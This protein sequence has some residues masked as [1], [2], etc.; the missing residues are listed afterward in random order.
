MNQTLLTPWQEHHF[1]I[2]IL[3]D[4]AVFVRDYLSP[5]EHT[6]VNEANQFAAAFDE[7]QTQ[8]TSIKP[9][10]SA[11]SDAMITFS[12]KA[13]KLAR[14]YFNFEGK[15]QRRRIRN[16][17]NI[18]L[19]PSYFNGTLDENQEYLRQLTFYIEG[20]VPPPLSLLDLMDLWLTDQVGHAALLIDILDPIEVEFIRK[21]QSIQNQFQVY[22]SKN[23]AMRGFLRFT[24]S[25]FRAQQRFA[26]EVAHSIQALNALVEEVMSLFQVDEVLNNT[27]LRFLE[28][29][30]PESCYF[31]VHLSQ[32]AP[33]IPSPSCSLT[34]PSYLSSKN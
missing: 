4:H 5:S 1:W 19:S 25:G 6:Y 34:K 30:F 10:E 16:E 33:S 3:S 14:A 11:S 29:H 2:E 12:Q 17:I 18:N 15:V 9:D 7:L 23:R 32:Y 26:D 27:T 20:K 24:P 28:H 31:L 8:L 13:Y 22:I 21:A